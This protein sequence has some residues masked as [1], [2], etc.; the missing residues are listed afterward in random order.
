MFKAGDPVKHRSSDYGRGEVVYV[1]PDGVL[2]VKWVKPI[3]Q[4]K[5]EGRQRLTFEAPEMVAVRKVRR[6]SA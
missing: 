1:Y 4:Y 6:A 2:A 3:N 5:P